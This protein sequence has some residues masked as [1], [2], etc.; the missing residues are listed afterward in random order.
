M[1]TVTG[2]TSPPADSEGLDARTSSGTAPA[3]PRIRAWVDIENPPQVQY[4]LPLVEGL[5]RDGHE[6]FVTAR[7]YGDTFDLLRR[8]DI[9]FVGVGHHFGAAKTA[10]VVG[11]LRRIFELRRRLRERSGPRPD[12]VISASR[13]AALAARLSGIPTFA[14]CDYEFVNLAAFRAARSYI[15]HPDV[16]S[17]EA[18]RQR[19]VKPSLLIPYP[20]IKE[21]I[22]FADIDYESVAPHRFEGLGEREPMK[23]LVRPP[24][25]ESHYHRE[26]SSDVF[27]HVLDWLAQQ[28]DVVVVF[29]PRYAWQVDSLKRSRW[30][31]QPLVL[32]GAVDFVSLYKGVDVVIS[33]GGT[34]IREA[35]YL[36][37]P[38]VSIFQGHDGDVDRHLESIGRLVR[39]RTAADLEGLDLRSLKR[40]EPMKTGRGVRDAVLRS[41]LEIAEPRSRRSS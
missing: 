36:G 8:R 18:F 33:G 37:L 19:G 25:E 30:Q 7:D 4:L 41:V 26:S 20:G 16:I 13:S 11:N 29:S 27:R 14:L 15:V 35:A 12:L 1:V 23:V 17:V 10:K 24:A 38:A 6:V 28:R 34:M 5:R 40:E 9:E 31:R 39:V 32:E 3:R 21:D 2:V 22:S